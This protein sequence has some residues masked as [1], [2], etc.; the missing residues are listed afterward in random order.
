MSAVNESADSVGTPI[1]GTYGT[2]QLNA[3][4]TYSYALDNGKAA[5]QAL[6]EGASA[7]DTFT[8]TIT[9]EHGGSAT[10][11]LAITVTGTNDEPVAE[12]DVNVVAE[13]ADPNPV[14][15]NVLD[16]DDDID[17][18]DVLE[19]SAVG[20][21]VDNV[22]V[23]IGGT[24]GTLQLNANGTYSYTLDNGK[25]AVQAL[26]A[27]E[28]AT[29]TFTYTVADGHG[30]S[31]TTTLTITV[32]GTND[33]PLAEADVNAVT[34]D[35]PPNA[36]SGNVLDNDSD[37]DT[38]AV[39]AVSA[40]SGSVENVGEPVGGTYGTLELN[41]DG[42]YS[43]TLDN[44]KDAVQALAAGQTATDVFSY[45]VS[46]GQGGSATATL[47]ITVTGTNDAPV[48]V[49]DVNAI[50]EDTL[51]NPVSGNVLDNDSDVDA[52]DLLTVSM[53]NGG[54]ANVG[55]TIGGTYGTLQLNADGTY[56]YT[57]DNGK[58]A[59]QALAAGETATDTFNYT[60]SD[61]QGGSASATL[62]ITVTGTDDGPLAVADVN[63]VTEDAQPNPVSGNVLDNDSDVDFGDV[64][65]VS[66]VND[67]VENVGEPIGGTYGTLQLNADG[68]YSYT[69]DNGK[70]AV[71]ALAEGQTA[72]DIF[73][74][75]VSDGHGGSATAT[76]TITVTGTNDQP[77]AEADANTV[78]EDAPSNPV[79]GNVLDNDLDVDAT[80]QLTVSTVAGSA[81]NVG[82]S[83]A[84]TYGTLV[85]NADG[86]YSYTLDNSKDVVQALAAGEAAADTFSYTVSDGHG[87]SATATL[88]ITVT[89]TDDGPLAVADANA[90]T[91]DTPPNPVSG[92]VLD[93]DSDVD[94]GDVLTVG[95]VNG[96]A[97]N[98][99]EPIG[100]TYGTLQLNADG[101][102]SYTLDNGKDA[103]Q[104]LAAGQTATDLFSYTVSDGHGGTA[105]ATLTITVTGTND[106]PVAEADSNAV[107]EDTPPNPVSGNVLDN[108][109]DVDATDQLTVS[110]VSG[111]VDNVG[112]PIEG[113]Y[114]TLLL[115][116]DGTY[117][118]T[119]DNGKAAV[120]TLG[121]GQSVTD[122]F[123]Y[124]VSDGHG[125]SA[126]ATLTITVTGSNDGPTA[127]ADAA[128]AQEDGPA[129]TIDVL[130]NDT[131]ADANDSKTVLSVDTVGDVGEG[132]DRPRRQR[133]QLR[134]ERGVPVAG[135]RR[136]GDRQL[137][138]HDEG[139]CG[140]HLD[141]NGDRDDRRR[142]MTGRRRSPTRRRRR[143]TGRRSPSTC[144]RTT[145]I[146]TPTT[147]RPCC[148]STR[149]RR[150][151]R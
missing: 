4:G 53:V 6:G 65:T 58:G 39:L 145:P 123:S 33:G 118:Y 78:T 116:A 107:T 74:Y 57:L 45:T 124:T 32:T 20:G 19:V 23:P 114:G 91:E 90:V 110:T 41:A 10:G 134:P 84:G 44:G 85:L 13:D 17:S 43:Y 80:D 79:S 7:V 54:A 48:A 63:A 3:D 89:G 104:A 148:R 87:G 93:N 8:Y 143:R 60:V 144:W 131:D 11:T 122:I 35:T 126:T 105:T 128:T 29:D 127:V 52:T 102:Y 24:Y 97:D 67:S 141:G 55:E 28:T 133:R 27:G 68:T 92:N 101:S 94:T 98:V 14:V 9:D 73:S 5:V 15:G 37:A 26:A 70:G 142:T 82:E 69:L 21:S 40:V 38:G 81:A 135:R 25:A 117:S 76:L 2:L 61:G 75:T 64:L 46:D 113:T 129:V 59:V 96:S 109:L 77:V 18:G 100:G 103:V 139:R 83:I 49:A 146:R 31:V 95:A 149:R 138:L 34:K 130:A 121:A 108:D 50:A 47:T 119:L 136:D 137:H 12:A 1:E 115:N 62:T 30:G 147:A 106:Q 86:T 125:G 56:S 16:N 42:T 88:T 111:S 120:Q 51:P 150:W 22:G 99:G 112:E 72:T 36:V 132:H 66:T 140:R 151:G 71:Q